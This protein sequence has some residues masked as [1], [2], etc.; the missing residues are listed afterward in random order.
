MQLHQDSPYKLFFNIICNVKTN[1]ITEMLSK[2]VILFY[3]LYKYLQYIYLNQH[4]S[5][6]LNIA[7]HQCWY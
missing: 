7:A 5:F 1:L 2:I 3:N 6:K 4:L